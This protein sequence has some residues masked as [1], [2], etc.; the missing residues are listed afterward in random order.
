MKRI[1]IIGAG[2]GGLT[3][4]CLLAIKGHKVTIFEAHTS[5][6]G[7]TA[8]FRRKGFYFESGTLAFESSREVFALMKEIGVYDDIDFIRHHTRMILGDAE[9]TTESYE[10]FKTTLIN[11]FPGERAELTA[12]FKE[13]DKMYR[14]IAPFI[15]DG[16]KG[17]AKV[18]SSLA[19]GIR[20]A[21]IHKKYGRLTSGEFTGRYFSK[22]SP[23]YSLFNQIG[24]PDMSASITGGA[25]ATIFED[26]WRVKQGM[27]HW[28]DVL[29]ARFSSAG[30]QLKT[31]SR[32][33]AIVTK[34]GRA[35]GVVC[36]GVAHD[37]DAVISACD[38]KKTFMSLL[39]DRTLVPQAL[40]E[41]IAAA[42]VSEGVFTVYLGLNIAGEELERHMKIPHVMVMKSARHI[43]A[44]SSVEPDFFTLCSF[45]L[46]SPSLENPGLAPKG[47]SSLMI[48]AVCPHKWMNDWG[49]GD[50]S[51]YERLKTS[52]METLIDKAGQVIPG[53]RLR[54]EVKDA[55][56]PRTYERYT[57]N[58]DGATSA[59]SWNPHNMFHKNFLGTFVDTPVKNL[60]IGSCWAAQI[61][62]VP[63]ALGAAR[64]CSKAIG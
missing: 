43:D 35:A 31:G 25:F 40:A 8:G 48:Q 63:G 61:G 56:T 6:G 54:I 26:Y 37:A 2:L 7:Y 12:Y 33:D 11:A 34:E 51:E 50:R 46:F 55:A 30:G 57:G 39:D 29:A 16:K 21:S 36:N 23:L 53:L 24:Y 10:H 27:G 15:L 58:T 4:G 22:D 3:A 5:P 18:V 17:I 20:M 60:Y 49:G 45:L 42:G 9:C 14:A 62:G 19:A 59:W 28:A 44:Q 1:V 64:R 13:T 41:K 52:V 32:I 38:Y 47:K